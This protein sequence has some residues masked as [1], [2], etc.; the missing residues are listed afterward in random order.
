MMYSDVMP[1]LQFPG[2]ITSGFN[3]AWKVVLGYEPAFTVP[4][5][6]Q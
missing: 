2:A 4:V 3:H 6:T 1:L 5:I